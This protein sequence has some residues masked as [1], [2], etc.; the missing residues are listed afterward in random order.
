M[1]ATALPTDP[2]PSMVTA[3]I[4]S[5]EQMPLDLSPLKTITKGLVTGDYSIAGLESVVAVERKSLPDLLSCIGGERE[6]FEK[7]IMRMLAFPVRALVIE[8]SWLELETGDWKSK[9]S[10][11]AAVGSCLG[12]I[13]AGLPVALVGDHERAG[14]FVSRLLFISARRRWREAR[15]FVIGTTGD[16]P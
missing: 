2:K 16:S 15:S 14:R 11:K 1:K 3:V 13:G 5:R 12:W 4:D 10:P 6:R 8:A 9:I 7:E